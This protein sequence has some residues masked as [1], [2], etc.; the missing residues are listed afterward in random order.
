MIPDE[1]PW[2]TF[3]LVIS[4]VALC[5]ALVWG[6]LEWREAL[7][8]QPS[9]PPITTLPG[10]T[11]VEPPP[12]L[13]HPFVEL[14]KLVSAAFVGM[15]VTAFHKRYHGE[16]PLPKSL[17]QAQILLCVAGAMI[18]VIIGNSLARAFGVAGAAGIVRFRTPVEDPKDTTV[19]FL[20]LGLGMACGLGAFAVAGLGMVFL[21][22]FLIVLDRFG[23][24]KRRTVLL[25]MTAPTKDFPVDQV[26]QVLVASVDFFEQRE[27]IQ[28]NEALV[29]YQVTMDPNTSL[30]Y[31]TQELMKAG[32]KAVSWGEPG[33]KKKDKGGA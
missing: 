1:G 12:T 14:L 32:L 23:E 22:A 5:G 33:E 17:E 21:S 2:R 19:I 18:M 13:H 7:K 29:R 10:V 30:T 26:N 16:K 25:S 8:Q 11:E 15:V 27:V 3:W 6:G 20:L 24:A 28:G 9:A 31:L 4:G